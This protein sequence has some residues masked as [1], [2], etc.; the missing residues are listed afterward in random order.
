MRII[1]RSAGVNLWLPVPLS[2]ASAAV[3]L[4]PETLFADM[5]RSV[6]PPYDEF[7]TKRYL[8]ELVRECLSVL[9]QYKKLEIVHV[10]A[11]DGTFV[12]IRL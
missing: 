2:L 8:R 9:K 7:L 1:V 11:A 12:S 3:A 10:E 6:P 4:L 5:R